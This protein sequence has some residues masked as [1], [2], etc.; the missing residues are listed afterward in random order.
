MTDISS[1]ADTTGYYWI[2][3]DTIGYYWILSDTTGYYWI[4]LDTIGYYWI[5]LDTTG[6]YEKFLRS[7]P[8]AWYTI[9]FFARCA[10][11]LYTEIFFAR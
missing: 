11:S 7:L 3:L 10:R 6:Y 5:L 4:L 8:L 9:F 2:L 1:G